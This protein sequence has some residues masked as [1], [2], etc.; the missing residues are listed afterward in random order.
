MKA[1][2]INEDY[3]P[4]EAI[5][6]KG[7]DSPDTVTSMGYI[8]GE[9]WFIPSCQPCVNCK[10]EFPKDTFCLHLGKKEVIVPCVE[11]DGFSIFKKEWVE[12]W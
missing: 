12:R 10:R 3:F 4:P 9:V 6:I 7:R 2:E 5:M 11:C 1:V 8:H